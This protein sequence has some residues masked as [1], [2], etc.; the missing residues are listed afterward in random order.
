M[1]KRV[2]ISLLVCLALL[3]IAVGCAP[4]SSGE[5]AETPETDLEAT[6]K[7]PATPTSGEA[8]WFHFQLPGGRS[9]V[10]VGWGREGQAFAPYMPTWLPEGLDLAL[11]GGST[12]PGAEYFEFEFHPVP[13]RKGDDRFIRLIE[14][15]GEAVPGLP[16][17]RG[18]TANG[19]RA[20]LTRELSSRHEIQSDPP[21]P[22][23]A[24][25]LAWYIGEVK[26]ELVSNLIEPEMIAVA[27][28]LVPMEEGKGEWQ[29]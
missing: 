22:A 4:T 26:I 5:T 24:R 18:A 3:T 27:E 9:G 15:V 16:E 23:G 11:N 21:T 2:T 8:V 28:S 6:I 29:R 13:S 14:G 25:L 20:V 12:A 17:G 1:F 19:Q 7:V 10:G